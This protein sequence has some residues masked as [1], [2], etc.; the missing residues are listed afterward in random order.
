MNKFYATPKTSFAISLPRLHGRFT[1]IEMLIVV[2]ILVIMLALLMP[3]LQSS[4]GIARQTSCANSM[5]NIYCAFRYYTDDNNEFLPPFRAYAFIEAAP[6]NEYWPVHVSAYLDRTYLHGRLSRLF[7]CPGDPMPMP[8]GE[9]WWAIGYSGGG[10]Y[11]ASDK[12]LPGW[13]DQSSRIYKQKTNAV[14]FSD[15]TNLKLRFNNAAS[16]YFPQIFWHQNNI[17][18]SLIDGGVQSNNY[19]AFFTRTY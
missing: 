1:I 9:V 14:L 11:G 6:T 5:R 16:M 10:S 18:L 17:N 7:L 12:C 3:Q 2:A 8:Y 19:F 15:N 13:Q 4:L